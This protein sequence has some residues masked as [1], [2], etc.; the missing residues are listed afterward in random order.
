MVDPFTEP[1]KVTPP[2]PLP[3]PLKKPAATPVMLPKMQP[4]PP[5]LQTLLISESGLGLLTSGDS[6]TIAVVH[7]ELV[8]IGDQVYYVEITTTKIKLFTAPRGRLVWEG[9]LSG[10]ALLSPVV[11]TAPLIFTPPL[12]AGVSPGLKSTAGS[13]GTQAP[14]RP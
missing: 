5:G 14:G 13:S 4:L 12:S 3:P 8:R 1:T 10:A 7:D 6:L 9:A 2:T 11:D